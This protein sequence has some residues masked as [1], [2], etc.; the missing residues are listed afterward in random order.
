MTAADTLPPAWR[1]LLRIAN[2]CAF[3][4]GGLGVAATVVWLASGGLIED[5][6]WYYLAGLLA[7][8]LGLVLLPVGLLFSLLAWWRAAPLSRVLLSLA[9]LLGNFPLAA[10]C[11]MTFNHLLDLH[12]LTVHN[13]GSRPV[14]PIRIWIDQERSPRDAW[15]I[16][17]LAPGESRRWWWT[18]LRSRLAAAKTEEQKDP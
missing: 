16:A 1:R 8:V 11:C 2:W 6:G 7:I 4:P 13:V 3:L 18:G 5:V 14:G 10:A 17:T 12:T 9:L 15:D